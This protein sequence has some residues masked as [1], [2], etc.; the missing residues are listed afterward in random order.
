MDKDVIHIHNRVLLINKKNDNSGICSNMD[1]P[2][3]YHMSEMSD[4]ER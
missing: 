2:R 1:A 4:T 3:N